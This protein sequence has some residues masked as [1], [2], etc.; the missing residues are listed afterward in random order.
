[1]THLLGVILLSNEIQQV[2]QQRAAQ[3]EV[4]DARRQVQELT[5]SKKQL[6]GEVNTLKE[7]L[8]AEILAKNDE[9]CEQFYLQRHLS[10]LTVV[11]QLSSVASR[12]GCKSWR[13]HPLPQ[14]PFIPVG[15]LS[16]Q[17]LLHFLTSVS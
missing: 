16:M 9:L 14:R 4:E 3:M 2:V 12:R 10:I 15:L 8:D 17:A 13:S 1:M 5:A 7:R 6:Q 11:L